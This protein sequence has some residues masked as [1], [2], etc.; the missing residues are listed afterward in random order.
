MC[1]RIGK[2]V[3]VFHLLYL[4][5]FASGFTTALT[6]VAVKVDVLAFSPIN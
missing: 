4:A 6:N 5:I 3:P 1:L 2:S